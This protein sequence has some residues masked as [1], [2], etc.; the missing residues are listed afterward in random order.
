MIKRNLGGQHMLCADIYVTGEIRKTD[1]TVKQNT[2]DRKRISN[3]LLQ[4]IREM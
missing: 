1:A 2:N 4:M 3:G